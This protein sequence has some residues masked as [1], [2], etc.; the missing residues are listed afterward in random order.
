MEDSPKMCQVLEKC[1]NT[2]KTKAVH[3]VHS[4]RIKGRKFPETN[5]F[6]VDD[7]KRKNPTI[8]FDDKVSKKQPS[9]YVSK[10]LH[11]LFETNGFKYPIIDYLC[12]LQTH[13]YLRSNNN[14][15]STIFLI[16]RTHK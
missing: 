4:K 14:V 7:L 3:R 9:Q 6:I 1:I 10:D 16:K 12:E 2:D 13:K 11:S 8:G 15:Q 5:L